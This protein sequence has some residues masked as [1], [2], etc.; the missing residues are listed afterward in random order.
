MTQF[1]VRAND[2]SNG[3]ATLQE[4]LF[5]LGYY[6][7][8]GKV[9]GETIVNEK[10]TI[11]KP[12][13]VCIIYANASGKLGYTNEMYPLDEHDYPFANA[14]KIIAQA[15]KI[16]ETAYELADSEKPINLD[17]IRKQSSDKSE[18]FNYRLT[19]IREERAAASR[20]LNRLGYV[21][22]PDSKEYEYGKVCKEFTKPFWTVVNPRGVAPSVRHESEDLARKEAARIARKQPDT[23]IL[24]IRAVASY[25]GRVAVDVDNLTDGAK[26]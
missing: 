25:I 10:N 12:L 7:V 2:V 24:V 14:D 11:V 26:A 16:R 8:M 5:A 13:T 18:S 9:R 23:E 22:N 3:G 17:Q 1:Q 4:A 15:N 21:Y 6:W 19:E 20:V